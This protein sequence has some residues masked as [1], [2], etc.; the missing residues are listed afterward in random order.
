M[1]QIPLNWT[2]QP[3]YS[4]ANYLPLNSQKQAVDQLLSTPSTHHWGAVIYGEEGAGKTHL[5]HVWAKRMN[6]HIQNAAQFK[7]SDEYALIMVDGLESMNDKAQQ[8]LFHA[9]NHL[10]CLQ[11]KALVITSAKPIDQLELLPDLASRL[12]LLNQIELPLP[13]EAELKIL[14]TKWAADRQLEIPAQVVNYLLT[15]TN[16]HPA[17]LQSVLV[18][19]DQKGLAQKRKMTVPFIKTVLEE[20]DGE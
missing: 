1:Q 4:A 6:A 8:Q 5:A 16:R 20:L 11:G 14:I 2:W 13:T 10:Q 9:F 15:H 19:A 12:K 18:A 17:L 3:D 7:F